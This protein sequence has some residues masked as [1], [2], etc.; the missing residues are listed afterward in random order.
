MRGMQLT[1]PPG[2]VVTAQGI[3]IGVN[4]AVEIARI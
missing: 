1:L 2:I 3:L 4:R